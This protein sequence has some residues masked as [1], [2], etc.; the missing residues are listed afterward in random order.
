M[1]VNDLQASV[2]A[3][4]EMLKEVESRLNYNSDEVNN[5]ALLNVSTFLNNIVLQNNGKQ[6]LLF[7]EESE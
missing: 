4:I 1:E 6:L 3:S 2:Q 7:D 5:K